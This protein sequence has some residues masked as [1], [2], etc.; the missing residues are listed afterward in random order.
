MEKKLSQLTKLFI[1]NANEV[2]IIEYIYNN[3][4][5]VN[6][7]LPFKMNTLVAVPIIFYCCSNPKYTELFKFIISNN[8]DTSREMISDTEK[9]DLL[10]FSQIEYIPP[11]I[12]LGYKITNV[13]GIKKLLIGGYIKKLLILLKNNA[14]QKEQLLLII[15]DSELI[16]N[17]FIQLYENIIQ[18]CKIKNMDVYNVKYKS[19]IDN[20]LDTIKLFITNGVNFDKEVLQLILNSYI[21]EIIEYVFLNVKIFNFD[22]LQLVHYSNFNVNNIVALYKLYNNDNYLHIKNILSK[23]KKPQKII[24]TIPKIKKIYN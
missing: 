24:Y 14:I 2:D 13:D 21:K 8:L 16:K 12:K 18:I 1:E 7:Y 19:I 17:V 3:K 20:Y 11:L 4:I 5:N 6:S 15:N 10:Y 9:I 23:Y 22:D